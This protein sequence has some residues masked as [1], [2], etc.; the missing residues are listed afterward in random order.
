MGQRRRATGGYAS[1]VESYW[2]G[3]Y[4]CEKCNKP[5]AISTKIYDK[6]WEYR[7]HSIDTHG[8]DTTILK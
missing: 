7:K 6:H 4:E 8:R 1:Q 3:S 5:H 2:R